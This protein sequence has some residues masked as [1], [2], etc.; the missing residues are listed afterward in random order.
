MKYCIRNWCFFNTNCCKFLNTNFDSIFIGIK[1][2]FPDNL[3]NGIDFW[4]E[5]SHMLLFKCAMHI[6]CKLCSVYVLYTNKPIY[7]C[8]HAGAFGHWIKFGKNKHNQMSSFKPM[9]MCNMNRIKYTDL[10]WPKGHHTSSQTKKIIITEC[11]KNVIKFIDLHLLWIDLSK[12]TNTQWK[13]PANPKPNHGLMCWAKLK[14]G[15]NTFVFLLCFLFREVT[16]SR[17]GQIKTRLG[18]NEATI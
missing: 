13:Q 2:Y 14:Y 18:S 5:M 10:K 15:P 11:F 17:W 9:W 16:Y 12:L 6:V 3:S 7:M 8:L 4:V 1:S